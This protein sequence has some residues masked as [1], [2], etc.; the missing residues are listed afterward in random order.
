MYSGIQFRPVDEASEGC[1]GADA[2][3][4]AIVFLKR[5]MQCGDGIKIEARYYVSVPPELSGKTVEYLEVRDGLEG[6]N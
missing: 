1:S 4:K 3:R 6:R 2:S 5:D